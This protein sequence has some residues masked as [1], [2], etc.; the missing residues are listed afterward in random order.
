MFS[1]FATAQFKRFKSTFTLGWPT[2]SQSLVWTLYFYL[3]IYMDIHIYFLSL[4]C[5]STLQTWQK[6][7]VW[8]YE[9]LGKSVNDR[10]ERWWWFAH[11]WWYER[12]WWY[13]QWW[14]YVQRW[15]LFSQLMSKKDLQEGHQ[16]VH[17]ECF[18]ASKKGL[19]R[20]YSSL[21]SFWYFFMK[22]FLVARSYRVLVINIKSLIMGALVTL[23]TRLK[24]PILAI[25][26]DFG[27]FLSCLFRHK[28]L[29]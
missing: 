19:P 21:Q 11:W 22:S 23:E 17:Q 9:G 5:C 20:R 12:R 15:W 1:F 25:F 26:D 4:G 2:I 7:A 27:H 14:W 10:Y 16:W 24:V 8:W 18:F 3:Y 29:D 6:W 13:A 28:P